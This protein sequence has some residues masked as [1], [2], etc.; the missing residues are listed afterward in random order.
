MACVCAAS[1]A[2]AQ[3]LDESTAMDLM[4]RI[5]EARLAGDDEALAE[6]TSTLALQGFR[7]AITIGLDGFEQKHGAD[8]VEVILALPRAELKELS[9]LQF[10]VV[11]NE[12]ARNLGLQ[13]KQT[14]PPVVFIGSVPDKGRT[15]A[16]FR[17]DVVYA[18]DTDR[19]DLQRPLVVSFIRERGEWKMN[20]IP[21]VNQIL[22]VFASVLQQA[23]TSLEDGGSGKMLLL[24]ED[25]FLFQ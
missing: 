14:F 6:G 20:S 9:D 21:R 23:E 25:A 5:V 24:R 7:R 16:L 22:N 17:H 18:N 2:R 4:N 1:A 13:D 8:A 3:V 19:L 11:L 15:Y 12:I 10:F